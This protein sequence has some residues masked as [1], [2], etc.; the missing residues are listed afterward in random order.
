MQDIRCGLCCRKLASASGFQEL[1]IKCPRCRTLNHIIGSPPR[2]RCEG[3]TEP[4]IC[5]SGTEL[6]QPAVV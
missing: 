3:K 1:Q 4:K 2:P 6:Q 5:T